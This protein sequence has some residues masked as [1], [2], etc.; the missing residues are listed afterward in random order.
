MIAMGRQLR[1][2]GLVLVTLLAPGW[3]LAKGGYMRPPQLEPFHDGLA[4]SPPTLQ[5]A[6]HPSGLLIGGC[7]PKRYRDA[8][9]HECRG[10]ADLR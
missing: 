6:S 5:T 1:S 10:P 2:I 8:Q 3:A 4:P 9:T 7:G